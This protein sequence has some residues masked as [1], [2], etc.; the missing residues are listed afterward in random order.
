VSVRTRTRGI[1]LP[2]AL[3]TVAGVAASVAAALVLSA[4]GRSDAQQGN[5]TP[6]PKTPPAQA[7]SPS[8][9]KNQGSYSLGVTMGAQ[10]RGL[11]LSGDA[12]VIERVTQGLKDAL[13]GTAQLSTADQDKVTQ[14]IE[15]GRM[16]AA[17]ANKT[18]AQK[19]LAENGKRK[20]VV[21][22]PSGL[23]YRV[24]SAGKGDSPKPTD[25]VTVHYRG[26]LLDGTEFDSSLKRGQPAQFPVNGVIKGWQEALVLMK[27]GAKYELFIPPELAYDNDSQPPIPPGSLLRF[28][29]ELLSVNAQAAGPGT[30][31]PEGQR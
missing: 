10:L 9:L 2:P 28:D 8:D 31:K 14:L 12:V 30:A 26:T 11:G 6:P 16:A 23:Q 18:A 7:S 5:Q 4:C 19:F 27:P 25:Q 3:R 20:G 21:T 22:T 29:V 1:A 24:V 13:A 17:N 15:G